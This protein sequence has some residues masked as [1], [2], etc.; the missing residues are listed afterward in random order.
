MS[1]GGLVC[2]RDSEE[3]QAFVLEHVVLPV[4]KALLS[5]WEPDC[6]HPC[7]EISS[8][9]LQ[10][11]WS[12]STPFPCMGLDCVHYSWHGTEV[13][14]HLDSTPAPLPTPP[15]ILGKSC[16]ALQAS[17]LLAAKWTDPDSGW[18]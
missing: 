7:L 3:A 6:L 16:T 18:S 9:G 8:P 4:L 14:V 2:D 12:T 13:L 11:S 17:L 15:V 5:H 10:A 1:G